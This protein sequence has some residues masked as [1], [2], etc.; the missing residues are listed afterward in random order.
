[1]IQKATYYAHRSNQNSFLYIEEN[2]KTQTN[3]P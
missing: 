2:T 1:M 3:N